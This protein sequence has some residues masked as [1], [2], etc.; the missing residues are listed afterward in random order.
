MLGIVDDLT[1][2]YF[3]QGHTNIFSALAF[4]PRTLQPAVEGIGC[5]FCVVVFDSKNEG[6]E[7]KD[8]AP[9]ADTDLA[10]NISCLTRNFILNQV[11]V[12]NLHTL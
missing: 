3:C 9:L 8:G 5:V 2:A 4:Y 12:I 6:C 11:V 7:T 1:L 10:D